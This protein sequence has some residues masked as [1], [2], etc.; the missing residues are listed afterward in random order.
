[1]LEPL[2][3]SRFGDSC[4]V[5][6]YHTP[7]LRGFLKAVIPARFNE[8]IGLQHMKIYLFDDTLIISG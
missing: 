5:S 2:L 1:M 7:K 3:Q 4:N 8:L 6:L